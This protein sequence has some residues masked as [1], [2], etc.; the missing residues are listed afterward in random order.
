MNRK[1]KIYSLFYIYE[2]CLQNNSANLVEAINNCCY[3]DN[4]E[5]LLKLA[6]DF[7]SNQTKTKR[8]KFMKEVTS[9][10][11]EYLKQEFKGSKSAFNY[12]LIQFERCVRI[13]KNQLYKNMFLDFETKDVILS[14]LRLYKSKLVDCF[15]EESEVED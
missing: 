5:T 12:Y 6:D 15:I 9:K 4:L 10:T 14:G 7:K 3:E 8:D 1:G 13:N 2:K 11:K